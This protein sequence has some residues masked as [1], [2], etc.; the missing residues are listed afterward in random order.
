MGFAAYFLGSRGLH[1][2]GAEKNKTAGRG[3]ARPKGR[4]S[5]R[6]QPSSAYAM[7]ITDLDPLDHGLIFERFSSTPRRISMPDPSTIDFDERGP[8]RCHPATSRKREVG[9]ATRVA[10][11]ITYGTIKA[12][13][14]PSRTRRGS[15][16]FP[17]ALG[18]RIYKAFP[19]G[20]DGQKDIP[21]AGIFDE[22]YPLLRRGPATL[23]NLLTN[24]EARGSKQ[25][26][27][28]GQGH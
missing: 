17:Y 11:I 13:G 27:R 19:P 26:H 5:A 8:R 7:G 16:G 10:Q 25:N 3:P 15:S 1:Q 28:H 20:R 22:D 21:L 6:R 12:R 24:T 9:A 18:D 14:R 2:L 23:R 4:G